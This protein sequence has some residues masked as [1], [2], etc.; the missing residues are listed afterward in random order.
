[1]RSR[2]NNRE[3][4]SGQ[5]SAKYTT[6]CGDDGGAGSRFSEVADIAALFF[7]AAKTN[8]LWPLPLPFY[9][10]SFFLPVKH[11]LSETTGRSVWGEMG[12]GLSSPQSP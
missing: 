6:H 10:S 4:W 7:F 11:T 12:F 3:Y 5:F 1:L 8:A 2:I 9:R